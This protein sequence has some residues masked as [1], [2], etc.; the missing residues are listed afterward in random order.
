MK[1][2]LGR[3]LV[4]WV[5][6]GLGLWI[7]AAILGSHHLTVGNRAGTIVIAGLVLAL[8]NMAIKPILIILSIPAL[9]LTLGL[10]MLIV[11]GAVIWVA[12]WLYGPLDVANFGWAIVAGVIVGLV[13]Y[14]VTHVLEGLR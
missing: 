2:L 7:A 6:S 11:N 1:S 4:R 9:I 10:F 5:A 13:N 8:V 12:S 14:L 3:F